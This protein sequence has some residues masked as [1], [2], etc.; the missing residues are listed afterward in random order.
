VQ[1]RN[2]VPALLRRPLVRDPGTG[3]EYDSGSSHIVSAVL[4]RAVG[5]ST[6][7][8][9]T[10]KLFG[11]LGLQPE[12]WLTDPQGVTS[13]SGGLVLRA[14]ELALL[15]EIARRG[16][17]WDG[18]QL[19]PEKW[20]A[21]ST[22]SYVETTDPAFGYGYYWW[23]GKENDAYWAR[24]YGGQL[25]AVVPDRRAVVVVASDPSQAPDTERLMQLIVRGLG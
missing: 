21:E 14:R 8:Y 15:G 10:E 7:D 18:Q 5:M 12:E 2:V 24:G 16:G 23:I 6:A 22:R 25:I 17:E 13:G 4:A 3:W 1:S 19:V 20:L 11:P 9:A